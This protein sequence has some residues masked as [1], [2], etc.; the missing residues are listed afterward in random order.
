MFI[1]SINA[2]FGV[3]TNTSGTAQS[4]QVAVNTLTNSPNAG[5]LPVVSASVVG[6]TYYAP[7]T[8]AAAAASSSS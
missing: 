4:A 1:G 8:A 3:V 7:T 5:P 6:K 2:F